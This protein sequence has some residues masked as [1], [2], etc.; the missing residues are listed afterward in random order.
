M[1]F[2][3]IIVGSEFSIGSL[4]YRKVSE[5]SAIQVVRSRT[6]DGAL[7][8]AV[9]EPFMLASDRQVD[10]VLVNKS[11]DDPTALRA[12]IGGTD[13]VGFYCLYRGNT[14][15]VVAMLEKVVAELRAKL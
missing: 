8:A 9:T 11:P 4:R 10:F 13:E 5:T 2:A 3:Q 14:Q 6:S 1:N 7:V 15:S 12:S